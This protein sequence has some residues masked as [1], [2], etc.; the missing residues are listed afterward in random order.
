MET[1]TNEE[2]SSGTSDE[3]ESPNEEGEAAGRR[4]VSISS[5]SISSSRSPSVSDTEHSSTSSEDT[6]ALK[7]GFQDS[8]AAV[9]GAKRRRKS[10]YSDAYR[11]LLNETIEQAASRCV[12]IKDHPLP[13]SQIG[14]SFWTSQEKES[15]F[16]HLGLLGKDDIRGLAGAIQSKSEIEVNVYLQ[17]LQEGLFEHNYTEIRNANLIRQDFP[18]GCEL[19]S[20]CCKALEQ[21]ADSL[22]RRENN[23]DEKI[24]QEKWQDLWLLTDETSDWVEDCLKE[25]L[26]GET[27]VQ[28]ALPA[29]VLLRLGSWLEL[30]QRIF[31]NPALT[32]D[33]MNWYYVAKK[34]KRPSMFATAFSD[35]HT[36]AVSLTERLTQATLFCAMSRLRAMDSGTFDNKPLIRKK[37]VNAAVSI[38]G[39][40]PNSNDFWIGAAR[41]C[42]L[43]IYEKYSV[44]KIRKGLAKPL[45]YEEVERI[46]RVPYK[47]FETEKAAPPT[48]AT[49]SSMPGAQQASPV[50]SSEDATSPI[51]KPANPASRS[52]SPASSI[53]SSSTTSSSSS[54]AEE[55]YLE[56]RDKEASLAE[57]QRM[58]AMLKQK[59]PV[60]IKPEDVEIPDPPTYERKS[61]EDLVDWRDRL[62]F[63]SEWEAFRKPVPKGRCD[64]QRESGDES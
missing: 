10:S 39:L 52:S 8:V 2:N 28:E 29:A 1:S 55:E 12:P 59:P 4:E 17:L 13:S 60:E 62:D 57:E 38:L 33:E 7:R 23:Y 51:P 42:K 22:A 56:V 48:E 18:A 16:E 24:E 54:N 27:E 47:R 20:R 44:R 15:L 49:N 50:D 45:K 40:K 37:D 53:K 30:S 46:L 25:G 26:A 43:D 34:E 11:G 61:R 64:R 36:L 14:I 35:F 21:A 58:W 19:S 3:A 63:Q 31:M 5:E 9:P 41:R 6:N 32:K